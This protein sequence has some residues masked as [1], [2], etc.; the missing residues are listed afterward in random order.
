LGVPHSRA[1]GSRISRP[2]GDTIRAL[3]Q[4]ARHTSHSFRTR[5]RVRRISSEA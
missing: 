2:L 4:P 1:S 3:P 5:P